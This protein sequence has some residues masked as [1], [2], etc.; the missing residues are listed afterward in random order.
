[1]KCLRNV[2]CMHDYQPILVFS[3]YFSA[4][5]F[6]LLTLSFVKLSSENQGRQITGTNTYIFLNRPDFSSF[7]TGSGKESADPAFPLL[8]PVN[9]HPEPPSLLLSMNIVFFATPT[10]PA[11]FWRI[12]LS[13]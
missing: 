13:G 3:L 6:R 11:K 7:N 4:I 12:P 5:L 10:S 1:M 8:S 9:T 2:D